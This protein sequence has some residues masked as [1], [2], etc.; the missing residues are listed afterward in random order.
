MDITQIISI[1]EF[2]TQAISEINRLSTLVNQALLDIKSGTLTAEK[3]EEYYNN[4]KANNTKVQD[5]ID[6]KIAQIE[7]SK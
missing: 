6:A 2:I 1:G 3:V 7:G 4:F 5:K